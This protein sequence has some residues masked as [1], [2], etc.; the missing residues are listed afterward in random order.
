MISA[1]NE[2]GKYSISITLIGKN[3][4]EIIQDFYIDTGFSGHLK[5]DKKL[6]DDLELEVIDK[7][8]ISLASGSSDTADISEVEFKIDQA[9]GK[10]E[11]FAVG[12]GGRNL[13]GARFLQAA[14][15]IFII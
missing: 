3:K 6:F 7:K 11:V 15:I 2:N 10:T 9:K 13:L 14:N 8:S 4:K 1:K 5:I 12:Y